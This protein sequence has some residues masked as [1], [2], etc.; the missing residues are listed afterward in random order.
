MKELTLETL[1]NALDWSSAEKQLEKWTKEHPESE[2]K[3]DP[4]FKRNW[5][6]TLLLYALPKEITGEHATEWTK[7]KQDS[8]KAALSQ[9]GV[10]EQV[11]D[12]L[13][14]H[15]VIGSKPKTV[16]E[17]GKAWLSRPKN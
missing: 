3:N 8:A 9:A 6:M 2:S 1:Y 17:K 15:D 5:R 13:I 10:W 14:Q 4:A 12:W 11:C 7:E 16:M